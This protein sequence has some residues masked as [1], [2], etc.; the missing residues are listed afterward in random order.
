MMTSEAIVATNHP[1]YAGT[2]ESQ[3]VLIVL[4]IEIIPIIA[5]ITIKISTMYQPS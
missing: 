2:F 5:H 4:T 1:K 3:K